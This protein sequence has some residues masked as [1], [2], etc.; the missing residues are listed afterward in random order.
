MTVAVDVPDITTLVSEIP[1]P[2]DGVRVP[3]PQATFQLRGL[4]DT[5]GN[6]VVDP[7]D[8]TIVIDRIEKQGWTHPNS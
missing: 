6:Q 3:G 7:A 5:A 4:R 1:R 2:H 8:E